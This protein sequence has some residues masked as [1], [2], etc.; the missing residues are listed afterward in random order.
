M[1]VDVR[2]LF[3]TVLDWIYASKCVSCGK[4]GK[5]ICDECISK[6][7]PVGEHFCTKC[8]KP[9]TRGRHCRHC[10]GKDFPFRS[11]RAPYLYEGPASAMIKSLKYS[12]CLSLV[13][14]LA[15][16]LADF[17]N[18]LSWEA[19][20]A[21]PVPLSAERRAER[22]FNQSELL[23][24]AFARRT[25]IPF[26]SGALVKIRHTPSQVGLSAEKR[27]ENLRG[28]FAADGALVSGKRV[29]LLDD[30]MTTGSTFAECSRVLLDEG[31]GP[32][33]CLSVA[34]AA[35]EAGTQKTLNDL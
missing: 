8:G 5:L 17:W 35:L 2:S 10:A 32:V 14:V 12:G 21:V 4:P 23:G 18:G 26:L 6:L 25:G 20:L 15:D 30:V 33:F 34:T 22:G 31:S 3:G 13:P 9:L 28:A 1:P 27:R 19:D 11:S 24:R 16:L 29:L 7:P